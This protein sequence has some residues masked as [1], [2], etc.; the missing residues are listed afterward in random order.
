MTNLD[1]LFLSQKRPPESANIVVVSVTDTDYQE[2]FGNKSPLSPQTVLELVRAC[3][4]SG[5]KVIA[6]DLDTSDWTAEERMNL[7]AA[8]TAS[9]PSGS[10]PRLAWAVGGSYD[11]ATKSSHLDE[12]KGLTSPACQGVPAS[13]PDEYGVVRGYVPVMR[14]E[15]QGQMIA[16]GN[17]AFVIEQLDLNLSLACN[18]PSF[19]V[20]PS[21]SDSDQEKLVNY[22]GGGVSFP[23]VSAETVVKAAT[24]EA[25]RNSNPLKDR[26]ALIGGSYRA[27]RDKYVTPVGY[28]DGVD[29]LALTISSMEKKITSPTPEVFLGI[30]LTLG[31]CLLTATW[32]LHRIWVLLLSFFLI[33]FFAI[34]LSVAAFSTSGYFFSFVPVL[35]GMFFH[36]LV[37]FTMEHAIEHRKLVKELAK[38]KAHAEPAHDASEAPA[39]QASRELS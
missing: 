11:P 21:D 15:R 10:A 30:D 24:A 16:A 9:S 17:F 14:E 32:F 38:W 6:V 35:L 25:W 8:V 34:L 1:V 26:I 27:A 23:H 18:P 4:L 19:S 36:K 7:V 5:A 28:L 29:I 33:P 13:M 20:V 31:I 22:A 37:E 12:L 39:A 3:A 2:M